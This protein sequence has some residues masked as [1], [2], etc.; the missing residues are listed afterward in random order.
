MKNL[1][2]SLGLLFCMATVSVAAD[3]SAVLSNVNGKVLVNQGKGFVPA[4]VNMAL[5]PGDRVFVG[6]KSSALVA[7]ENCS[8]M[9]DKPA[10]VSIKSKFDCA[11]QLNGTVIQPVADM[12]GPVAGSLFGGL[13]PGAILTGTVVVGLAGVIT[14]TQ[15]IKKNKNSPKAISAK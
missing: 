10:V 4:N 6:E 3:N 1:V 14:Y 2:G 13:A 5:S 7:Y 11:S 8:V 9:V 12:A 15:V